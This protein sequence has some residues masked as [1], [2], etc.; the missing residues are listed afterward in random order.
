MINYSK[1]IIK[2]LAYL[3][4]NNIIHRD[5][6][7][8]NILL[9]SNK[10][11]KICDFGVSKI[12]SNENSLL[13]SKVGTPMYFPPEII[14][15]VP[16]SNKIDIWSLGCC[17]YQ[18]ASFKLPFESDNMIEL[19]SKI[20]KAE[21][22]PLPEYFIY[23]LNCSIIFSYYSSEYKE[24]IYSLLIKSPDLRPSANDALRS[25]NRLMVNI[26]KL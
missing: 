19:S 18:L 3:H 22:S 24:F 2:G 7:L 11:I 17:L 21:F 26:R 1:Q 15:Q 14:K 10:I 12:V 20:V 9:T 25:I 5:I 4:D 8:K 23:I 16:Y 13:I 6:K